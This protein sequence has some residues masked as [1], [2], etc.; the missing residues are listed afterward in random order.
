MSDTIRWVKFLTAF[1]AVGLMLWIVRIVVVR[2]QPQPSADPARVHYF[3]ADREADLFTISASES[4]ATVASDSLTCHPLTDAKKTTFTVSSR[5]TFRCGDALLQVHSGSRESTLVLTGFDEVVPPAVIGS[6]HRFDRADG[7]R[8]LV[9]PGPGVGVDHLRLLPATDCGSA[10][11]GELVCAENGGASGSMLV[12][13]GSTAP[14]ALQHGERAALSA[15]AEVWLG[16]VP[17]RLSRTASGANRFEV[18]LEGHAGEGW[19]RALGNRDWL[20]LELPAWTLAHEKSDRTKET[21]YTFRPEKTE[22]DAGRLSA[23]RVEPEQEEQMQL[24]V[25]H[26]LLCVDGVTRW[27]AQPTLALRDHGRTSS[28]GADVA[29]A[30]RIVAAVSA[31]E[32]GRTRY[33][34]ARGRTPMTVTGKFTARP[35]GVAAMLRR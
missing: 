34:V 27:T 7:I 12:F 2:L 23:A 9:L 8:R 16:F 10:A 19:L 24:L 14:R 25:D 3:P 17:L 5:E 1:V 22:F 32:G 4:G 20:G 30:K 28:V 29:A 31:G 6:G 13:E 35:L 26:E 33:S 11:A 15:G 18:E 21:L